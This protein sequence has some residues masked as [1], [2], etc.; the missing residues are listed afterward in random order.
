MTGHQSSS[1]C[2]WV[3][4][5]HQSCSVSGWV[6]T[7]HQSPSV[8]EW[9]VDDSTVLAQQKKDKHYVLQREGKK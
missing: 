4:T 2:G 7:G 6:M 1:V 9:G 5:G 8:S 3:M